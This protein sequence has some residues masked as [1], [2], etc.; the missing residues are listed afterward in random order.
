MPERSGLATIILILVAA[1]I[2]FYN[3]GAVPLLD[4]DEPVYAETAKEMLSVG[5][6]VSPRIYGE[7]WYDKPPMYYWLVAA[8]FSLFGVSEFASRF[9]SAVL[10]ILG[11]LYVYFAGSRLFGDRAGF[12]GALV[13][14][15][16]LEYFYL[17][18]AAVT[19]ITLA[20]FLTVALLAFLE[21][22]YYLF[23]ICAG[24]ATV[25]KGPVGFLFPG[26]VIFLYMLLTRSFSLIKEMKIP[27]GI[28]LFAVT[29]L[30][31][32]V[33]M[34]LIHGNAFVDTFLGFHNITRFTSPE[35][36][37]GVLWYYFIPVLIVGFL[38]WTAVMA[39]AV[40]TALTDCRP[41]HARPLLFLIIWAAFIFL[42]FTA[43][44]T[45]LVSYILPM[46]PPLAMIVGWYFAHIADQRRGARPFGWP[47]LLTLI[48]G[49]FAAGAVYAAYKSMPV[50]LPGAWALAAVFALMIIGTWYCVGRR[51]IDRAVWLNVAGMALF[52]VVLMSLLLPPAAPA[53]HSRDIARAFT[54]S[55]DG[56][57]PVY[58]VKF[59][60]PGFAFYAGVYGQELKPADWTASGKAYFVVRKKEYEG[61]DAA[62][63]QRL[64]VLDT[65]DEKMLI[66]RQ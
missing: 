30:P 50:L 8:S 7:Y 47:L 1:F 17:G 29:A 38:P 59:L 12:T 27:A 22:R 10:A 64:T 14:I 46:F 56:K 5:D 25:T 52:V 19:D 37:E 28:V 33:A 18:K 6:F 41:Q 58:I 35:H 61:L 48:G 26:A 55:Y 23:Y 13:L 4:P 65:A 40:W 21:K 63:K 15:A 51:E 3:L 43:S 34:Y 9:P 54:A 62:V 2:M 66:L 44:R 60:R 31:W 42:F 16:S 49:L 24:L 45:K 36:P 20:F 57:S 39:Q 11:A 32:Y 53:F